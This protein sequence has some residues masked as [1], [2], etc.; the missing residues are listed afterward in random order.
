MDPLLLILATLGVLPLLTLA[1]LT[2]LGALRRGQ[3]MLGAV[4]AGIFFPLTWVYWYVQDKYPHG[5][6]HGGP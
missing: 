1:A 6:I 3:H 2:V 5:R 4:I